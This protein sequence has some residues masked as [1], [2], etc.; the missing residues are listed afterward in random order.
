MRARHYGVLAAL[1]LGLGGCSEC[2][3]GYKIKT[4]YKYV[5]GYEFWHES[6][7]DSLLDGAVRISTASHKE[8][9]SVT[10]RC[11]RLRPEV[12]AAQFDLRYTLNVPLLKRVA[13]ELEKAGGI[14]MIVTVDGV[15]VGTVK[16]RAVAHEFG[17]SFLGEINRQLVDKVGEAK[18]TVVVMPRVGSERLDDVVEFGVAELAK[19]VVPI[20]TACEAKT[21]PSEPQQKGSEKRKT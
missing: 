7:K 5:M 13:P 2:E 14:E 3:N 19:H 21:A 15:P 9:R 1:A 16:A 8:G 20:K 17:I 12:E 10:L 6:P 11:F 18:K 4:E